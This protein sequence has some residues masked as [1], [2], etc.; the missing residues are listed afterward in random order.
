MCVQRHQYKGTCVCMYAC[1]YVCVCMCVWVCVH[2]RAHVCMCVLMYVHRRV[3]VYSDCCYTYSWWKSTHM[4]VHMYICMYMCVDIHQLHV[5]ACVC[6]YT[7][8][9]SSFRWYNR[10]QKDSGLF[11][12]HV[13]LFSVSTAL[14]WAYTGFLF[15]LFD[16][17]FS[18][19]IDTAEG[20]YVGLS[21]V[22]I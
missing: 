15:K 7:C 5:Y 19:T 8:Q 10:G 14:F 13:W 22:E 12:G 11:G 20:G 3:C 1:V 9:Y 16:D 6:I 21:F 2:A 4:Y 18:K 17:I